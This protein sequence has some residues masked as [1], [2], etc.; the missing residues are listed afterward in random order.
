MSA[1]T[2]DSLGVAVVGAGIIGE[3]HA[4]VL[5]RVDG[6]HL[7]CVVDPDAARADALARRGGVP[8]LRT[9]SEALDL[10]GVDVV[11]LCTPSGMHAAGAIEAMGA[12]RDVLIEKPIDVDPAR[13]AGI[14]EMRRR[15]GRTVAVISQH[16]FDPASRVLLRAVERG[17][18]GRLTSGIASLAWWR[19]DSYYGDAAWRGTAAMDGGALMNQGIHALDL[20]LACL[21]RPVEV[22]GYAA[23]LAH[24][25]LEVE[26][27][28]VGCI[29]FASGAL[30]LLHATTAAYPGL[31]SRVQVHGDA[32]SAVIDDDELVFLHRTRGG[33]RP[34]IAMSSPGEGN[35]VHELD[36]DESGARPVVGDA[37]LAQYADLVRAIRTGGRPAVG[38]PEA[39]TALEVVAALGESSRL[40][41]P[42]AIPD[43]E[44]E[45]DREG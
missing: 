25:G 28:A 21:G 24:P 4:E 14:D 15:T 34:E 9:L 13:A 1:A 16:R 5:P 43:V 45:G 42:V 10:D 26:D 6:A 11:A 35:Q 2:Q 41:R 37:H 20:L 19:G 38:T 40:G 30:G 23:T 29:R 18:L 32:G 3:L 17:E 27:T 31:T 7:A 12:G 8:S 36:E 39:R 44:A 33:E 22:T